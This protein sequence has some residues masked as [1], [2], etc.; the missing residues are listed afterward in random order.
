MLNILS[1]NG[2]SIENFIIFFFFTLIS[3]F[4]FV[5]INQLFNELYKI[6]TILAKIASFH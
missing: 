6:V 4:E 3:A 5:Q 1:S 2:Q